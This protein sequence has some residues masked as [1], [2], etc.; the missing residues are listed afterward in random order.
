MP[1][2]QPPEDP[3]GFPERAAPHLEA[4]GGLLAGLD[5]TVGPSNRLGTMRGHLKALGALA[6]E[7]GLPV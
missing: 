1:R 3:Q 7:A 5:A 2:A 6:K 4:L